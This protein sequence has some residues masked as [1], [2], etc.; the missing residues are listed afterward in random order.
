[1]L[2]ILLITTVAVPLLLSC[3]SNPT[4]QMLYDAASDY[5]Y[6]ATKDAL[7]Y[8]DI[9]VTNAVE[10]KLVSLSQP[11]EVEAVSIVGEDTIIAT[12][13]SS[14][15]QENLEQIPTERQVLHE[16]LLQIELAL[17]KLNNRFKEALELGDNF[18]TTVSTFAEITEAEIIA[19]ADVS[20]NR[21]LNNVKAQSADF[22]DLASQQVLTNVREQSILLVDELIML[23]IERMPIAINNL[24]QLI[25]SVMAMLGVLLTVLFAIPFLLGWY[26]APKASINKS[27]A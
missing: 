22:V 7:N 6:D 20:S 23:L 24:N 17:F 19:T 10:D 25:M 3:A 18:N 15:E 2:R 14:Q 9:G 21:V 11:P 8:V 4:E 12:V 26:L 27:K 16:R 5:A 13:P 1:M